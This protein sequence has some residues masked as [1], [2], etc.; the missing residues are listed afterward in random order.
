MAYLADN[1][2][3]LD[4]KRR[5][6]LAALPPET[7]AAL[8]DVA[9][10]G[11]TQLMVLIVDYASDM[12]GEQMAAEMLQAMNKTVSQAYSANVAGGK[13]IAAPSAQLAAQLDKLRDTASNNLAKSKMVR[14]QADLQ[15]QARIMLKLN[16]YPEIGRASCRERV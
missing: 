15:R 3:Q 11:N 6:Y 10:S 12:L 9:A 8:S 16:G 2:V 5:Q 14:N 13:D 7:R 4:Q 1:S